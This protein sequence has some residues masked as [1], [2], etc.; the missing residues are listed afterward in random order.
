VNNSQFH[1]AERNRLSDKS[2]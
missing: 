2:F 1:I